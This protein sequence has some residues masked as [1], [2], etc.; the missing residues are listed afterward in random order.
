M[1]KKKQIGLILIL[2]L[3]VIAVIGSIIYGKSRE[4][5]QQDEVTGIDTDAMEDDESVDSPDDTLEGMDTTETETDETTVETLSPEQPSLTAVV[6]RILE[7]ISLEDA[8]PADDM[9]ENMDGD[10]LLVR[11]RTEPIAFTVFT[12]RSTA[13]T[14]CYWTTG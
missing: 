2:L 9:I 3:A 13:L 7:N 10:Q 6:D 5:L 14:D 12:V 8:I 4:K 11:L 1:K